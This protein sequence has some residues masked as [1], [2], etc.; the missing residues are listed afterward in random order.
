VGQSGERLEEI[1]LEPGEPAA[2]PEAVSALREADAI[3]LGPGSLFTS[4]VPNLLIPGIREALRRSSAPVVLPMNLMTQPGETDGMDAV[5]HLEVVH[6]AAGGPVVD[7]VLVSSTAPR[8]PLLARYRDEGAAPVLVD[9][10]ALEALGPR[11]VAADLLDDRELIRHD[12]EKLASQVVA[13][14][15]VQEERR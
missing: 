2:F 9:E 8:I 3:V 7:V 15:T 13:A 14:A 11:V 10:E 6:R 1:W 12:P 4:I 5:D